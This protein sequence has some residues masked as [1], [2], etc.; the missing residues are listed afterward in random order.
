MKLLSR[1]RD[2]P[3]LRLRLALG[4]IAIGAMTMVPANAQTSPPA[5][6]AAPARKFPAVQVR[7]R[8]TSTMMMRSQ[9]GRDYRI[10]ISAPV[11]D[12]PAGG[13]PVIYVLDAN[14]WFGLTTE[15][16]RLYE[17]DGGPAIVVGVGYPVDTLYSVQGRGHDFTLGAPASG[18]ES[19]YQGT[20]F[21]GAEAFLAF[22]RGSLRDAI[23]AKYKIDR[24]RQSLFGHSLGGFFVFHVLFTH[25]DA[26]SAY[27]AASPALWWDVPK[28][29][30]EEKKAEAAPRQTNPP[31]VLVTVGSAEQNLGAGDINLFRR[32]Y[33]AH[34]DAF[35]GKTIDQVLQS[36]REEMRKSGFVDNARKF[37]EH[38][39]RLG[40]PAEC[41]VYKDGNHRTTVPSAI[42]AG[43]PL[44]L[45]VDL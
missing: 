4:L 44:F 6:Q 13:F 37:T 20:Q 14:A 11:G 38:L 5:K 3:G 9:E 35:G 26:F 29:D 24:G 39:T 34:P 1:Y 23:A 32:M 45:H 31:K 16:T 36:T 22:L 19:G 42:M 15:I 12:P 40:F 21:G 8:D 33:A 27:L 41:I 17:V 30:A 43:M 7:P 18:D 2:G 25:P 10:F 28:L